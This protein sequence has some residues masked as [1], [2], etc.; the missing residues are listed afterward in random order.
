MTAVTAEPDAASARN[1]S[2]LAAWGHRPALDGLRT[3]AVYAVVA[4]HA[5]IVRFEGGYIGVDLF[6]VLSGFLVT[7]VLWTDLA[8]HGRLRLTR[9][10]AR[11]VRR[12]VPAALVA[13]LGAGLLMLLVSGVIFRGGLVND[14]RAAA[15]WF[16]NWHFIGESS[17]YFA[18]DIDRSPYLHYWSLSIE[19]QFYVAFPLILWGLAWLAKRANQWLLIPAGVAALAVISLGL[20]IALAD[21]ISRAYYGTDT[22]AYQLLVGAL[23]ALIFVRMRQ[24]RTAL[25]PGTAAAAQATVFAALAAFVVLATNLFDFTPSIRG[26]LAALCSILLVGGL[27]LSGPSPLGRLF[28][29]ATMTWL[30]RI[31]YGTYL[32]H[33]PIIVAL[34]VLYPEM[35]A[36]L[37]FALA[38]VGATS[39]AA[40]S[41][42]LLEVPLRKGRS[43]LP[44]VPIMLTGLACSLAVAL[45]VPSILNAAVRPPL[46]GGSTVAAISPVDATAADDT[47]AADAT[48]DATAD[49]DDSTFTPL[50]DDAAQQEPADAA[51]DATASDTAPDTAPSAEV[52]E[53]EV[54]EAEVPTGPVEVPSLDVL[55]GVPSNVEV[56]DC[57]A[58]RVQQCVLVQGGD[59]HISVIGDSSGRLFLPA[60]S[61][62]AVEQG[63]TLSQVTFPGCPWEQGLLTTKQ[64]WERGCLRTQNAIYNA[65]LGTFQPDLVIAVNLGRLDPQIAEIENFR[66]FSEQYVDLPVLDALRASTFDSAE[67]ILQDAGGLL[68]I[69]PVP[70]AW[71]DAV[72]CLSVE[73]DARACNFV[74]ET[75]VLPSEVIYREVAAAIDGVDSISI[76]RISCPRYPECDS[77][78]TGTPV[79]RDPWHVWQGFYLERK[80]ELWAAISPALQ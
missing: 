58:P 26:M 5:G 67:R 69:E 44:W 72:E 51:D 73:I 56:E 20:Q 48:T 76:D 37:L 28:S 1:P 29:L 35:G 32:W 23:L 17:D 25:P 47:S 30:G 34:R 6:F 8:Q 45:I 16:A 41:Y 27:E 66:G 24:R 65:M 13:I 31:S 19:E 53:A 39:M 63:F 55:A 57:T 52:V 49:A 80:A 40:L 77:V 14:A 61:E 74:H 2:G 50:P 71:F 78:L 75:E 3:L 42:E 54:V 59:R 4:F 10:Y 79:Y 15:L 33:W 60:L 46:R 7:N 11:R 18:A 36:W 12:L 38:T 22:R 62:L 9:F 43:G 70:L 68:I 64:Q 21:N